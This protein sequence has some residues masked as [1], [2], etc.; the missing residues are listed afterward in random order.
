MQIDQERVTQL[1]TA[2]SDPSRLQILFLLGQRGKLNV[3]EIASTF[4][5]SRPTI[6][7]HLKILH[8]ARV[9]QREQI[10]QEVFYGFAR[11]A[12]VAEL[13]ELTDILEQCQEES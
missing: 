2:I 7:H 12:V 11:G 5:L 3:G 8:A 13:R 10:G 6:S 4:A 1:L 9:V